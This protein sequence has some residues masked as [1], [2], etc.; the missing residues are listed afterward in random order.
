MQ[1]AKPAAGT[2]PLRREPLRASAGACGA[3]L[4]SLAIRGRLHAAGS[5]VVRIGI[6]GC[7]ARGGGAAVQAM[8]VDPGVRLVAMCDLF[9]ER[10]QGGEGS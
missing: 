6:I 8:D 7:G 2:G 9:A 4:V 3:A 5:D 10:V 1:S